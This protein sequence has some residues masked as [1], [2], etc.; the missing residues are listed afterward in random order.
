MR[1]PPHI[2]IDFETKAIDADVAWK[3]PPP[4]GVSLKFPGTAS[5]YLRWG[6]PTGNNCTK[7]HAARMLEMAWA[8]KYPLVFHH[9]KYDLSVARAHFGLVAPHW[10]R[11]HDT[12]FMFYLLDPHAR[13]N[14]LKD[15]AKTHLNWDPEERDA[16]GDWLWANR[17]TLAAQYGAKISRGKD[18]K[19][20]SSGPNSVGAWLW[21]A[22]GDIVAPYAE[23]DTERTSGLF[24]FGWDALYSAGMGDAYDRE[25]KILPIFMENERDG[26]RIDVR[27]LE[28]DIATYRRDFNTCE[29][30]LRKRLDAPGLSFDEDTAVAEALL[31]SGVVPKDNWQLTKTGKLS[32]SKVSLTRDKYT[33]ALVFA[34]LGY[35]NRLQTCLSMFM[36]PWL[37]QAKRRGGDRISTNWNQ[38]RGVES[39]GGT[40]TGRPSTNNPNFL[41]ISKEFE[42]RPDEYFHPS[43]L[44]VI[45]LPLVRKY[46]LPDEGDTFAHRDFDGQELRVFGHFECGKLFAAYHEN[47]KLDVHT[48]VAND[49]KSLSPDTKLDR[50]KTKIINFRTIYGSGIAGLAVALGCDYKTAKDFKALHSQA[51]PGM[52]ILNDEIKRLVG[53]GEPIRTWGG[54]VYYPEE[55]YYDEEEGRWKDFIYKLLNYLIQG[56]A[57]DLTK[58]A[59]IDW[60]G[61]PDRTSRFLVTV[62]DEINISAP[63]DQKARQMQ[64]LREC[65][66]K[67][68]LTV[69]MLSAG[70]MGPNWGAL[71]KCE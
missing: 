3:P 34:A 46:I 57:A 63:L 1:A 27:Q 26:I 22:P 29:E 36:E 18:G 30:W 14:G 41:N 16:I 40:R 62:Y 13:K 42:N 58:E 11:V 65:M 35:R 67:E 5:I 50:T 10:S 32:V 54:R 66:E 64:I 56:S 52:K 28:A 21:T 39:G 19:V 71:E 2:T 70:K 68:R 45:K 59:I 33:D 12:M 47:P 37:A 6:H 53:R 61:H 55:A 51:L 44:D 15:L 7:E 24:T 49:I 17:Y 23:G 8:S 9:A 69:P 25:R 38:T 20:V 4:V 60:H 31:R 48:M 43:E